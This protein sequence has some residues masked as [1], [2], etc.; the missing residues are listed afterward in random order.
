MCW[1]ARAGWR[2]LRSLETRSWQKHNVHF[3][4]RSKYLVFAEAT[5]NPRFDPLQF[6]LS[7][8]RLLPGVRKPCRGNRSGSETR[9]GGAARRVPRV[10]PRRVH[11]WAVLSSAPDIRGVWHRGRGHSVRGPDS[12]RAFPAT[13]EGQ[14]LVLSRGCIETCQNTVCADEST[15]RGPRAIPNHRCST[16]SAL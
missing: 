5:H 10:P 8:Q 15:V 6:A 13:S 7:S 16:N 4:T 14:P 3:L 12:D 2:C 1:C 9:P 11:G